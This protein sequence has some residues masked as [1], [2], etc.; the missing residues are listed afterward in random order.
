MKIYIK[1]VG[2]FINS[3]LGTSILDTFPP[4]VNIHLKSLSYYFCKGQKECYK[5]NQHHINI[6][7]VSKYVTT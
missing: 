7:H 2:N 5:V 6:V 1:E 3:G 4:T